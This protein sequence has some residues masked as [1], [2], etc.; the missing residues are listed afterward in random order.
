[1]R[2]DIGYCA[3]CGEITYGV[4]DGMENLIC[5]DCADKLEE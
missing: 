5:R 2:D 3:V 4:R 1:M